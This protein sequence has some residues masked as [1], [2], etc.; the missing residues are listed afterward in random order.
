M[1]N[2]FLNPFSFPFIPQPL[3][4]FI[5][6][7]FSKSLSVEIIKLVLFDEKYV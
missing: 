7:L 5:N 2:F 1:R 6:E 3:S 4:L